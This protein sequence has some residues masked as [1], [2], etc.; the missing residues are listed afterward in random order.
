M[1][2]PIAHSWAPYRTLW[3]GVAV[4]SSATTSTVSAHTRVSPFT[5]WLTPL[6]KRKSELTAKLDSPMMALVL[7][8]TAYWLCPV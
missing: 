8:G 1:V 6:A 5:S 7:S 4:P 3:S 2:S